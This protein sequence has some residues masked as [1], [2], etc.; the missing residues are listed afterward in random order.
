[1]RKVPSTPILLEPELVT[2][3]ETSLPNDPLLNTDHGG[4]ENAPD[5]DPEF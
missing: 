2:N 1:M 4:L 3:S 5:S